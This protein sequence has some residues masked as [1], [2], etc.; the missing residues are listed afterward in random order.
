MR[1]SCCC[2]RQM[3]KFIEIKNSKMKIKYCFVNRSLSGCGQFESYHKRCFTKYKSRIRENKLSIDYIL[4]VRQRGK[5]IE[6]LTNVV[7]LISHY[8]EILIAIKRKNEYYVRTYVHTSQQILSSYKP[9][10]QVFVSHRH[11]SST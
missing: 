10:R 8:R 2:D 11:P 7:T 3:K 5:M 1:S 9:E 6:R 4:H